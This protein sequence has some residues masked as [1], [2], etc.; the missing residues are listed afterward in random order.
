MPLLV[1]KFGGTSVGDTVRISNVADR[2]KRSYMEGHDLVIILSAMGHTTDHLLQ[3]ALDI[4]PQPYTQSRE[5]DMLLSTGEQVSIALMSIALAAKG[6]PAVSL[7]GLQ[8]GIR[9]VGS[10]TEA[11]IASVD[12]ESIKKHLS[13]RKVCLIAGFQGINEGNEIFTLGRGGSD[14]TAVAVAVALHAD[15]CEIYTDVDGVYTTDPNKVSTAKR[16]HQI[17]Y[18]E[19]L[20]M[21]R[22][23]A[24]VLHSRSVELASKYKVKLHVRSSFNNNEGSYV[25]SEEQI[26]EK[27]LVRGVSLKSDEARITIFDLDDIPGLAAQLFGLMSQ[28]NINVNLI[29]QSR[30]KGGRNTISYTVLRN[31]LSEAKA[32][33]LEF[34]QKVNTGKVE[35]TEEIA[36]VSAVGIGMQSHSGVAASMFK[37]LADI[38][39]NIEMISTS[40]IKVSVVLSPKEGLEALHAVHNV[41]GLGT[42]PSKS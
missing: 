21:A 4:H 29:V 27:A 38:N 32:T 13:Q 14:T 12:S 11:R 22:L 37:A 1:Q 34:T 10:H 2:I 24:G 36:I 33:A 3:M 30:G 15:V 7:T 39:A 5:M 9:V 35:V 28:K 41:F 6:V 23:G 17:S 31:Q 16:I 42:A 40:E 20:E 25:V 18:E 26:L 8:A 19:M